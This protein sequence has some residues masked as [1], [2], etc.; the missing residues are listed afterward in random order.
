MGR[1][2]IF[3][4]GRNRPTTS[5]EGVDEIQRNEELCFDYGE[6]GENSA[7]ED[8]RNVEGFLLSHY[9]PKKTNMDSV[10]PKGWFGKCVSF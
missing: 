10:Y 5:Q 9:T 1:F 3:F 6:A 4:V 8:E 7:G 2:A